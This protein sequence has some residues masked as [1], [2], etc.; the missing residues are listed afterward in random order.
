MLLIGII[1]L[2]LSGLPAL[3]WRG[4]KGR[5]VA[6]TTFI[7]A[8]TLVLIGTV[9]ALMEPTDMLW[10]QAWSLPLGRFAIGVDPLSAV[11]LIPVCLVPAL[12][13]VYGH[14]Y[15]EAH[16]AD[17]PP[18]TF[19]R[20]RLFYGVLT[21][22]LVLLVV[23][24]DTILFLLAW[25]GMALSAF[26]LVTSDDR[27]PET[28]RA[29]W[30]YFVAT[31]VGT[32]ALIA[33]FALLGTVRG[34]TDFA[35][36][37]SA[38][39]SAES[40]SLF[41][42][43]LLGFGLKAG[44]MPF[45]VWLP[46]AHAAA[47]S[48]I[49]AILSG[50]V[51]KMGIYGLVRT[52]IV[53][54]DPPLA[55]GITLIVFGSVSA[56]GAMAFALGQADLKRMLAYST[57]ENIGVIVIGIGLALIGKSMGRLDIMALGLGGAL[58][59][60]LGHSLF[61]PLLFFAAGGVI[62]AAKTRLMDRMG[63]LLATM[64]RTAILFALG[65][66]AICA[67]PPFA[68]FASEL[69]IYLGAFGTLEGD[70]PAFASIAAVALALTGALALAAFVRA[71]G[72]VFLGSSRSPGSASTPTHEPRH[73]HESPGSML[74]PTTILGVLITAIGLVPWLV[75][76][77]LDRVVA[78]FGQLA[79]HVP[80][81]GTPIVPT[82]SDLAPLHELTALGL[83]LLTLVTAAYL[84]VR[85]RVR[86]T[87]F[88]T[89]STWDCGYA[90]PTARM[91]YTASSFGA[92]LVKLFP[93]LI[94]PRQTRPDITGPHPRPSTFEREVPDTV[95]DTIV[96]PSGRWVGSHLAWFRVVQQGRLQIYILYVLVALV[97]LFLGLGL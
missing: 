35:P 39:T 84:A 78:G 63:G 22:S 16:P 55:W 33:F 76:P 4:A 6:T 36:I 60:M 67:L 23:A 53:V 54:P 46:P 11:F 49:S 14:G 8:A 43:G 87:Q 7:L 48:H 89:Q 29:G 95:L 94:R 37:Q 31:H 38:I 3:A 9:L 71:F 96:I 86:R 90:R 26:F 75:T 15:L 80:L 77:L 85:A 88:R 2:F 12:G 28:R 17:W 61:K 66:V 32:L 40:S 27:S 83:V 18:T 42:L 13:L 92:S 25:E 1:G 5:T 24:R 10:S 74:V 97:G 73:S 91:Q 68:G 20:I 34:D 56:I 52:L 44:L 57:I 41:L 30:I 65:A 69:L 79:A 51:T 58:L 70:G 64:P 45:H 47:P 19:V 82:I 59:H 81:P 21:G 50:V 72:V 93:W 62:H